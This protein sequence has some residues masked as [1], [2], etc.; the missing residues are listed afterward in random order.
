MEKEIGKVLR[1]RFFKANKAFKQGWVSHFCGKHEKTET[2]HLPVAT[3]DSR[4]ICGS[5]ASSVRPAGYVRRISIA[6]CCTAAE[7]LQDRDD[8][9]TLYP[10][11]EK[12]VLRKQT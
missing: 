10:K 8:A 6:L 4:N 9:E 11:H 7:L 2:S 3:W 1:L 12:A 5:A